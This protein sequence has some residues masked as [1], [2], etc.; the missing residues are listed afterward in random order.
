MVWARLG[1][2]SQ[3]S[4]RVVQCI[5]GYKY[6]GISRLCQDGICQCRL[7]KGRVVVG[8]SRVGKISIFRVGQSIGNPWQSRL[9]QVSL[10]QRRIGYVYQGRV[11]QVRLFQGRLVAYYERQGVL[12]QCILM[13]FLLVYDRVRY[14]NLKQ[15]RIVQSRVDQAKLQY[16]QASLGQG[17]LVCV[18][19]GKTLVVHGK[20][21]QVRQ[22]SLI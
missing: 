9:G 6:I 5:L 21:Y 16:L 11:G 15:G 18:M 19:Q 20:V 10:R 8:Y 2:L 17:R 22:G 3:N 7:G 14:C 4:G 1:R 13:C 12:S